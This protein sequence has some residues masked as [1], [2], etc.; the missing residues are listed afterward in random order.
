MEILWFL[1]GLVIGALAVWF[2]LNRQCTA[3]LAAQEAEAREQVAAATS[4]L[5]TQIAELGRVR[6]EHQTAQQQLSE[7][8]AAKNA[9]SERAESLQSEM[10]AIRQQLERAEAGEADNAAK[11][12]EQQS[13]NTELTSRLD[14]A[15]TLGASLDARLKETEAERIAASEAIDT[16]IS[17]LQESLVKRDGDVRELEAEIARLQ[18][19]NVSAAAPATPQPEEAPSV[20]H[21]ASPVLQEAPPVPHEA[22]SAAHEAPAA[23]IALVP[24]GPADDLT[25]IK[26]I[27]P[28]LKGKL[29]A[30]GVTTFRQ[31]ADFTQA[32]IERVNAELDFPGRIEREQW[33]EQAR[34][35]VNW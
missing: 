9:A 20:S 7:A 22:P 24:D 31:I 33:I 2:Y 3:R 11:L 10:A 18:A 30:L 25:K 5:D 14:N 19:E 23:D 12:G 16:R 34:A 29:A 6:T 13:L 15:E 8:T 4:Q 35:M 28:V 32:D 1:I 26:G 17:D 21:D 27:G